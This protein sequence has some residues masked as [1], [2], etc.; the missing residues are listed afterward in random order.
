LA[1]TTISAIETLNP[2]LN[3]VVCKLYD[4]A[5]DELSRLGPQLPFA[6]VPFLAK[7]LFAEI[8]GTPLHEGSAF[9]RDRYCS[10]EDSELVARWRDA[11]LV[12]LGKTNT[13]EFGLKP[14][15]EPKLYGPTINPWAP[16]HTTG[17]SSGGSAAA[18]A[19][20]L[21]PMAH[22]NDGW[23]INSN[24]SLLLWVVR[25]EAHACPQSSGALLR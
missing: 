15:C 12:I 20:R 5:H 6:G 4:Q 10:S 7:D 3:A 14:D 11:G 21:V 19:A 24:T 8:A 17:G 25:I 1:E 2:R 22:A 18:V 9:L 13:P 23:R 16:G